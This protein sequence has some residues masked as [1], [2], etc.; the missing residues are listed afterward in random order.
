VCR[1]VTG[2]IVLFFGLL[3]VLPVAHGGDGAENVVDAFHA[4]LTRVMGSADE[5]GFD[6]RFERLE[7][8][9]DEYFD[10]PFISRLVSG[11]YW[12][13]MEL[14]ERLEMIQ[15]F[16]TLIVATYASRFNDYSGEQF[17]II[18][19]K[20]IKKDRRLIRSHLIKSD[21]EK[22]D[23][24]Y[25]LHQESDKWKIINVIADG[26]SDLSIKRAD[27]ASVLADFGFRELIKRLDEQIDGFSQSH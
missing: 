23:I 24:D 10:L 1:R 20:S 18:E 6:G 4:S 15:T 13:S 7:P 17:K 19:V 11:R 21:G 3:S 25:V 22:V 14:V 12:K 26:V 5:L 9:I 2:K 16:G 8:A 27:Y